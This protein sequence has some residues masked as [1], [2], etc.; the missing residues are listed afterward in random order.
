MHGSRKGH[1]DSIGELEAISRIASEMSDYFP[2]GWRYARFHVMFMGG[3]G[4]RR[5][6]IEKEGGDVIRISL[7]AKFTE[8]AME[9]RAGMYRENEGTWF[10]WK[11]DLS[12]EGKFKSNFNYDTYPPFSF[13]PSLEDYHEDMEMYPRSEEFTP[14]WFQEGL[15][16]D[17]Q[18]D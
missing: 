2:E 14:D 11:L 6:E 13:S 12:S 10:S 17:E 5:I 16:Q 4:I 7:P 8:D 3:Y 18:D 1:L 15:N 9:I